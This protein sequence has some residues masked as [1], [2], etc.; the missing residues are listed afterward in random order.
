MTQKG[1]FS[2]VRRKTKNSWPSIV[3]AQLSFRLKTWQIFCSSLAATFLCRH[4]IPSAPHTRTSKQSIKNQSINESKTLARLSEIARHHSSTRMTNNKPVC[5]K[6]T[7][8]HIN[9]TNNT[10]PPPLPF[11]FLAVGVVALLALWEPQ[12][13]SMT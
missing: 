2:L 3:S 13:A 6:H 4:P 10:N 11:C 7:R 5:D 9:T 1:H 8:T 12:H